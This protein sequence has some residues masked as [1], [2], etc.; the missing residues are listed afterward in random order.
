MRMHARPTCALRLLQTE[1]QKP[2]GTHTGRDSMRRRK[3]VWEREDSALRS[4]APTCRCSSPCAIRAKACGRA[5]V[6][7]TIN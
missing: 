4:V 2:A 5:V 7:G 6:E 3:M 1:A